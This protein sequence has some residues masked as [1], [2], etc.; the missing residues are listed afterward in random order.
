MQKVEPRKFVRGLRR[1]QTTPI[2]AS[3][4]PAGGLEMKNKIK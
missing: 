4:E 2:W 3:K 1:V